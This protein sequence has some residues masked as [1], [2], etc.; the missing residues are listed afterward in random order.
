MQ[1]QMGALTWT[2]A[3]RVLVRGTYGSCP[4]SADSPCPRCADGEHDDL[5]NCLKATGVTYGN[6][7]GADTCGMDH[8]VENFGGGEIYI[9][10][11]MGKGEV[12]TLKNTV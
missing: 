12:R 3:K 8:C 1:R 5:D 4:I 2:I 6:S 7:E 9:S 11:G 10:E